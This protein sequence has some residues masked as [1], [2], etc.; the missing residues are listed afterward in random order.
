MLKI[1]NISASYGDLKVLFD[2]SMHV[3][4]GEIVSLVG[5]NGAGKT[6]LLRV[7]S[8]LVPITGGSI[9]FEGVDLLS[10]KPH[11]LADIGIAHIP[12]GRGILTKLSVKDNLILGAYTKRTRANMKENMEWAFETFPILKERLNKP[13]GSLSGGEQQM[14]S[15]SRAMMMEPKMIM[16]DEPSLGLAPIIV[17]EVFDIIRMV[18]KQGMSIL[19][20]EQNLVQALSIAHRGYVI[21]TGEVVFEG[22][23][24]ELLKNPDIKKAYLSI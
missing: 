22:P 23:A 9:T 21:E 3:D 5:S 13:A 19:L 4:S 12:Q 1:D 20:V 11:E 6:T 7:I 10:K 24:K 15:L 16:M 18:A 17:D 14:L 2:F 8:R